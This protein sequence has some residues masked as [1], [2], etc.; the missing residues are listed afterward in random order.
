MHTLPKTLTSNAKPPHTIA[1]LRSE[2]EILTLNRDVIHQARLHSTFI[3]L[4]EVRITITREIHEISQSLCQISHHTIITVCNQNIHGVVV[5]WL[6]GGAPSELVGWSVAAFLSRFWH[7]SYQ[8]LWY[9]L[10]HQDHRISQ[11]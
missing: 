2:L 10:S 7:H 3:K 6:S 8:A 1:L 4:L 11:S 9:W 5:V